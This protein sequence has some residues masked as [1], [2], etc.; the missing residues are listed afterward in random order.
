MMRDR[1]DITRQTATG[2]MRCCKGCGQWMPQR[3]EHFYQVAES[4]TS[5]KRGQWST[6]CRVCEKSRRR[7]AY[8]NGGAATAKNL[9]ADGVTPAR[10]EYG[11]AKPTWD[12]G[13]DAGLMLQRMW[14]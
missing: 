13:N 7:E 1:R 4:S 14:R 11:S 9:A 6:L 2:V 12:F 5:V 8:R 3:I 10:A